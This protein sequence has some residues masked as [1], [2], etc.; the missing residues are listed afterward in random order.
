METLDEYPRRASPG[1]RAPVA[2]ANGRHGEVPK[3]LTAPYV[4]TLV[5][6]FL[7]NGYGVAWNAEPYYIELIKRFD[8]PQAA[9]AL[10]SFAVQSIIPKLGAPLSQEKWG[11][12]V[13]LVAP[14]LTEREDRV[15][16]ERVRAFTGEM[17]LVE[18]LSGPF[19]RLAPGE[20]GT[21][22]QGFE[23]PDVG[24]MG[25]RTS[26]RRRRG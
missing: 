14:K 19:D 11:E 25:L 16:L 23:T 22:H 21:Q 26:R 2:A 15:L 7:T 3:L 18:V 24:H 10:R 5:N 20:A 1:K 13:D 12:L 9:Y 8:G 17:S 6:V 4:A